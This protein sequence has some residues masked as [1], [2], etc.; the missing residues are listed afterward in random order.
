[1]CP[2]GLL[3]LRRSS[4]RARALSSYQSHLHGSGGV[5]GPGM[6]MGDGDDDDDVLD[7][8]VD[9]DHEGEGEGEEDEGEEHDGLDNLIPSDG[10]SAH[11]GRHCAT[12]D[13]DAA[14]EVARLVEMGFDAH[15]ADHAMREAM[16][17]GGLLALRR[18]GALGPRSDRGRGGALLAGPAKI[19]GRLPRLTAGREGRPTDHASTKHGG[20]ALRGPPRRRA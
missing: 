5:A 18:G 1:M 6:D 20:D 17:E 16:T 19:V 9:L 2:Q 14:D 8:H 10:L 3:P 7:H 13:A 12:S 15:D 4:R 11:L